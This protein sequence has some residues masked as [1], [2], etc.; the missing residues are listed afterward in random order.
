MPDGL[1]EQQLADIETRANAAAPGP[2]VRWGSGHPT[3][4]IDAEG[5]FVGNIAQGEDADFILHARQ[6]VPALVAEVRHARARIAELERLAV[7]AKHNQVR[8]P[9]TT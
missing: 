6:D 2:W 7:E 9:S 3:T 1:T 5:L 4:L 8:S